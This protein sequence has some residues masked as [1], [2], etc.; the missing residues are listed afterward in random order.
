[1]DLLVPWDGRPFDEHGWPKA[2]AFPMLPF[3]NR[4]PAEGFRWRDRLV[5]P[6]PAPGGA[7]QHGVA[8]RRPWRVTDAAADRVRMQLAQESTPGW[9]WAWSAD[10]VIALAEPGMTVSLGVR[11]SS[12]EA[13]PLGMGWHPYHPTHPGISVRD[14]AF[15][16]QARHDLDGA[17][18]AGGA[19]PEPTF[20]VRPGETAAFSA[21]SGRAELRRPDRGTIV[22]A[23]TGA[24][25]L[26]LHRPA[27]GDYVCIEPVTLLPGYLGQDARGEG[28]VEPGATRLLSWTCGLLSAE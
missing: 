7:V 17:G 23:C 6:P 1:V 8:H 11:N 12:A 20:A 25:H 5:Q 16:A 15:D 14:L 2:G 9:P 19:A 3:A 4:L 10:L 18:R 13:M 27:A 28:V 21:W 22:V 24:R 26:V